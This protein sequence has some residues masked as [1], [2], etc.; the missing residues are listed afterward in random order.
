MAYLLY[1]YYLDPAHIKTLSKDDIHVIATLL[2]FVERI[3]STL[4]ED[5]ARHALAVP[6]FLVKCIVRKYGMSSLMTLCRSDRVAEF[7]WLI[8]K[9]LQ[10]DRGGNQVCM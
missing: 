7:S 10:N 9:H 5:A 6:D 2:S 4:D 1:D 8:P 3:F